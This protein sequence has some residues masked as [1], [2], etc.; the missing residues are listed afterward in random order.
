MAA[1]DDY[2]GKVTEAI[3]DYS[4]KVDLQEALVERAWFNQTA[5]M[6]VLKNF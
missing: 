4:A 5:D 3:Y 6:A 2:G 1:W